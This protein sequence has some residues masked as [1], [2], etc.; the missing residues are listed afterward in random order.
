[1]DLVMA[2]AGPDPGGVAVGDRATLVG[3]D[4]TESVSWDDWAGWAETNTYEVMS[5][6]GPRV[7]REYADDG[8]AG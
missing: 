5:R 4:G 7:L 6:I 2:D 3:R 8:A 1:M